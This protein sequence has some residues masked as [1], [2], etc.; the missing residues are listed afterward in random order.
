MIPRCA[1]ILLLLATGVTPVPAFEW[2]VFRVDDGAKPALDLQPS[3]EFPHI[4]Y[5]TE[6]VPGFIKHGEWN[7]AS[8][9]I[10]EVAQGYFYGPLDMVVVAATITIN[11]IDEFAEIPHIMYHDHQ[12]EAF[13]PD[14]GDQTHAFQP[15]PFSAFWI[16]QAVEDE[17]HDGWDNAVATHDRK[18]HTSSIDPAQFGSTSGVEYWDGEGEV[19]SIGSGPV[20]YEFGTSIAVDADG[21]PHITYYDYAVQTE[22]AENLKYA[23][24]RDGAWTIETVDAEPGAGRYSSVRIS[25]DGAPAISYYASIATDGI[26]RYAIKT[27]GGW[28]IEEVD[29]IEPVPTGMTGARNLTSL[30]FDPDGNPVISYATFQDVRIAVG[31]AAGWT[32]ETVVAE[33]QP[34]RFI[35]GLTSLRVDSKGTAHIAYYEFDQSLFD[36]GAGIPDGTVYYAR[37]LATNRPPVF[38]GISTTSVDEGV[39]LSIDIAVSDPDGDAIT[40]TAQD[41]PAGARIEGSTLLWTPGFDQAGTYTVTIVAA[42]GSAQTAHTIDIVVGNANAPVVLANPFP[43]ATTLVAAAGETLT[44]SVDATDADGTEPTF[45]WSLNGQILAGETA[46]TLT[47]PATDAPQDVVLL[48]ATDGLATVTRTWTVSRALLGDFDGSGLVDFTDFLI[49]A[50]AFGETVAGGADPAVDIDGSGVVDFSDFLIFASFF[51]I[52]T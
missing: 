16:R 24:K 1:A 43:A 39:P 38:A 26:I 15:S 13:D 12:A 36:A 51:G 52:G 44:F 4:S 11:G 2:Q 47:I 23:V 25:P 6:A 35:G 41:L 10:S 5:M 3:D 45:T 20:D 27:D 17:G 31:T 30:D 33:P 14:R 48:T 18:V 46:A 7:G 8:F 9:D 42:D 37:G 29:R 21:N 32:V 40:L 19:E 49:F 22:K 50:A 28:R 34:D